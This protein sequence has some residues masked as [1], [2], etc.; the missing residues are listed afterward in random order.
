MMAA[1]TVYK[2]FAPGRVKIKL[3]SYGRTYRWVNGSTQ[4]L[5]VLCVRAHDGRRELDQG[6]FLKV[7]GVS[8]GTPTYLIKVPASYYFQQTV[9]DG[10]P[11]AAP[12]SP[13]HRSVMT[14]TNDVAH[15]YYD[16]DTF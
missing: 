12:L 2:G 1:T 8:T 14:C 10:G 13:F 6:Q 11:R 4:N 16:Y 5:D 3:V 15:I 9:L 7:R